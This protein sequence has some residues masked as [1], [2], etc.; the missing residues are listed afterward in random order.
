MTSATSN[1]SADTSRKTIALIGNPNCGKTT[2]FNI[3][4]GSHQ[5]VG[6]WPGVTVERKSGEYKHADTEYEVIDLPGTYSLNPK[7]AGSKGSDDNTNDDSIDEQIAQQFIHNKEADLIIN[8]LDASSLERGLYLT[9]QLFDSGIPMIVALNMIDVAHSKGMHLDHQALS[10]QLGC[11][12]VP[13]VASKGDGLIT[14]MDSVEN[15]LLKPPAQQ[16]TIDFSEDAMMSEPALIQ[17]RY[18]WVDQV[19]QLSMSISE[20]KNKTLSEYIDDIV[21]NRVLALPIF[22]GVMY[23]LFMFAINVGSAFIDFFDITAG[24]LFVE[25]PRWLLE[26]INSPDWLT[27][28]L[29]DGVGGGIQLVASFIP[30]I[31][32]LFLSLSFLEDVGFMARGAFIIDRMMRALGLPGKAFVPLIVGFG[33]N[34]PSVMAARTLSKEGDRLITTLMAPFMSCGARLTVYVLFASAFFVDN[35]ASIVF[36]LYVTGIVVAILSAFLV[37]RLILPA[38]DSSFV[39]ELPPYLL[40]TFRNLWMHTWHRL[41]GFVLRAGK[42]IVAVVII[43]N[44]LNSLGTD[45]SFGNENQEQSALSEIGRFLTPAFSPMGIE[46]DNWPAT[47]GIFT[48]L[49]AKEVVVGTLD[50]LYTTSDN[51]D[52]EFNLLNSLKD[53][54]DSISTNLTDVANNLDDPLGLNMGDLSDTEG[55]AQAQEI[56]SSTIGAIQQKFDGQ[57]G[58][59]VYLLF[60]LLYM[61][62]VATLGAIVKE[63]GTYWAGFSMLWSFS[64]A[65]VLSVI[66][67]QGATWAE[68]P[69]SSLMWIVGLTI[70]QVILTILLFRSGKKQA[71]KENLIPLKNI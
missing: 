5:H 35:G 29:A 61:P 52:E 3:L 41:K 65:Y 38:S 23:L 24:A 13:L 2:L 54:V 71:V 15:R 44:V 32:A 60:I 55:V 57:W 16:R 12:V 11:P 51:S 7:L 20:Q 34:V 43:L 58:A 62:C 56:A 37:R 68:H 40:P 70:W 17:A 9:S 50:A 49:F 69:S 67:Y 31:A 53:A 42:A 19:C 48:G 39:M 63:H 46:Q 21:L 30:V 25:T 28:L 8:V 64:V 59:F 1:I 6:N 26:S 22:M 27:A 47:V 36:A 18:E 14:L 10:E 45:G 66:L 33:C 4:T